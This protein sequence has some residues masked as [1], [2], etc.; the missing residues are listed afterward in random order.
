MIGQ[1][2]LF[3][4]RKIFSRGA[5]VQVRIKRNEARG[6]FS[7]HGQYLIQRNEPGQPL[8]HL[9]KQGQMYDKTLADFD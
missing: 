8:G 9:W 5:L 6:Q 4:N 1:S 3:A 2:P 7:L